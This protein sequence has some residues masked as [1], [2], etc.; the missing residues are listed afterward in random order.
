MEMFD[1]GKKLQKCFGKNDE[2]SNKTEFSAIYSKIDRNIESDP[3]YGLAALIVVNIEKGRIEKAAEIFNKHLDNFKLVKFIVAECNGANFD[4]MAK[5]VQFIDLTVGFEVKY[6]FI[7]AIYDEIVRN[8]DIKSG[9]Y[10]KK[11]FDTLKSFEEFDQIST[12]DKEHI[13]ILEKSLDLMMEKQNNWGIEYESD[14][15]ILE[16]M[17]SLNLDMLNNLEQFDG[18]QK[19]KI[20]FS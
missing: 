5:L 16:T 14:K 12:Y 3:D 10:L 8:S 18:D 4:N 13:G 2:N 11:M 20:F 19:S 6:L 17:M 1:L 9:P 15:D 7:W